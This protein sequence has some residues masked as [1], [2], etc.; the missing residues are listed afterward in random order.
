MDTKNILLLISILSVP[1][2]I[3]HHY[4]KHRFDKDKSRVQKWFQWEDVNNHE[5]VVVG[6][7]GFIIGLI[8]CFYL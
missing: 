3:L 7:I 8:V 6:I 5:T 4:F 2:I 1:L